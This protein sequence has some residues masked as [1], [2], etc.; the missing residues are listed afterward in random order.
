MSKQRSL[1]WYNWSESLRGLEL[2]LHLGME[3]FRE[4]QTFVRGLSNLI[5]ASWV[6]KHQLATTKDPMG[7]VPIQELFRS[8]RPVGMSV[9]LS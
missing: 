7:R 2:K 1:G 5:A 6:L 3:C 4:E 8:D 9:G